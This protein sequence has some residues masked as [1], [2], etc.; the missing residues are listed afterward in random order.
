ME[1][2]PN[3][4][5]GCG[6]EDAE[7]VKQHPFFSSINWKLLANKKISPPWVPE[8]KGSVDVTNFDKEFT[9]VSVRA[10]PSY[11]S[12]W[13]NSLSNQFSGFTFEEH[14]NYSLEAINNNNN[15]LELTGDDDDDSLEMSSE[16]DYS[17]YSDSDD[18][19]DI[20]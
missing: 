14:I 6:K 11:D 13:S 17:D 16:D 9:D 2:D 3:K 1:K 18:D 10:T 4:R 12:R 15:S 8:I 5:L 20:F 19:R 7:A